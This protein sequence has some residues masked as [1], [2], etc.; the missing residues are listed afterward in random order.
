MRLPHDSVT[1]TVLAG[2]ALTVVLVLVL[3]VLAN[4][5]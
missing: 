3:R 5:S 1:G 4:G 2:L